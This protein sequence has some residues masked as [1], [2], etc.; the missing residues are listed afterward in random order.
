MTHALLFKQTTFWTPGKDWTW[1]THVESN[2]AQLSTKGQGKQSP[3]TYVLNRFIWGCYLTCNWQTTISMCLWGDSRRQLPDDCSLWGLHAVFT[4]ES[5]GWGWNSVCMLCLLVSHEG[6]DE[7]Q[8]WWSCF[9]CNLVSF[10]MQYVIGCDAQNE[11]IHWTV[12]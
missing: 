4:C 3:V 5:W 1:V 2:I 9:W 10:L 8:Q 12:A 11:V 6:G 7:I